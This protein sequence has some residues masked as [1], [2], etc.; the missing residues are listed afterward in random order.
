MRTVYWGRKKEISPLKATVKN[1][2]AL[3]L[4]LRKC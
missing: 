3:D 4:I 1:L 2:Y